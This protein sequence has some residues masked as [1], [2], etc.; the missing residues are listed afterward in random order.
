MIEELYSI[1][2]KHPKVSIDSRSIEKNSIF[3]A[4]KGENFDGNKFALDAIH[5]GAQLSV[6]DDPE[7]NDHDKCF[8][9]KNSLEC[10]QDLA[11]YHRDQ[12]NIPIIA[13]TGTN[14]K[15]TTKELCGAVL[16]R[17]YK[18]FYTQGNFNNHIGVPLSLL[19]IEADAEIAV[20][21]MGANHV[22]EIALL[23]SIAKPNHGLITNVGK[24]HL[25]G[26][27]SFQ[28][29]IKTKTE[30]YRWL[31]NTTNGIAFLNADNKFLNANLPNKLKTVTYGS[32]EA[33]IVC[34]P[35]NDGPFAGLA[36]NQQSI[37]SQL[38]GSYNIE[39]L[40]AAICI[41]TYFRVE[42]SQI[43]AAVENFIP[44]NHRSQVQETEHNYIILDAYNANPSSMREAVSN[45]ADLHRTNKLLILGDMF[46]LGDYSAEEHQNLINRIKDA[47]FNNVIML[48]N[49]FKKTD[50]PKSYLSFETTE[51][52]IEYLATHPV[53]DKT[54][55]IKGSRG[56]KMESLVK[57]F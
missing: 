47:G 30:L 41:G 26:F 31:E 3:F 2:K 22:G 9:V 33:D 24:A 32:N 14:G 42:A 45:F 15:T 48:G 50:H 56:M 13:I 23:C 25:E 21:E 38:I 39:N 55:L 20:I 44:Q 37:K 8:Y 27:G 11:R 34:F 46:E 12:L 29:I 52:L 7:L 43:I 35:S 28:N 16:S 5:K 57:F 19:S 10:L 36:W 4:I 18:T 53:H 54:I 1:Y 51:Q 17:K 49:E 40:M 6:V